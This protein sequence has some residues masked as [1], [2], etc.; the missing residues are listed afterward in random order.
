MTRKM[1]NTMGAERKRGFIYTG[2]EIYAEN[3]RHG[4]ACF[5]FILKMEE[6][7]SEQQ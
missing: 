7:C 4:G 2:G 3:R 5:R 1:I 6:E